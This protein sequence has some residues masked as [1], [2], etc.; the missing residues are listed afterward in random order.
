MNRHVP[1]GGN[2]SGDR[3]SG[4]AT[5]IFNFLRD[6]VE[7]EAGSFVPGQLYL[8]NKAPGES[9]HKSENERERDKVI[10]HLAT[11]TKCR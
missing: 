2:L 1:R 3:T 8:E 4:R 5:E 11:E 9:W 7:L 10:V 6:K